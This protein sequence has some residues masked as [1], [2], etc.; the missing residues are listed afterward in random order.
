[1]VPFKLKIHVLQFWQVISNCFFDD[2]VSLR[3]SNSDVETSEVVLI[4]S[5][6]STLFLC[7]F[8]LCFWENSL[9]FIFLISFEFLFLYHI[10]YF[11]ILFPLFLGSFLSHSTLVAF[12]GGYNLSYHSENSKD[13]Y[14]FLLLTWSPFHP[15]CFIHLF[16]HSTF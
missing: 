6:F 12:Y 13:T 8:A 4:L 7:I 14:T 15:N 1:M 9:N 3:N 2:F 5:F 10:F 11:Q 16:I